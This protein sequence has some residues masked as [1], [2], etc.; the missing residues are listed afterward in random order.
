[1]IEPLTIARAVFGYGSVYGSWG[2]SFLLARALPETLRYENYPHG[3][4]GAHAAY[5]A[6]G[7]W[8]VFA[9]ILAASVWMSRRGRRLPLL[10]QCGLVMSIFLALAPGFGAQYLVWLVAFVA[11]LGL[12]P[13][14]VYNL[15]AGC[16]LCASYACWFYRP[17][18]APCAAYDYPPL[19]LAGWF[20]IIIVAF[21]YLHAVR[22]RASA[23]PA[24]PGDTP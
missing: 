15:V 9:L 18:P 2:W 6:A 22:R 11:A 13:S 3:L 4:T 17:M 12:F 14:L 8:L 7:K 20:S 10:V 5:A 21:F 23:R 1:L 19:M 24:A 16:F